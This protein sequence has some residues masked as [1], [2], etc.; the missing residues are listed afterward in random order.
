MSPYVYGG[1]LLVIAVVSAR[2]DAADNPAAIKLGGLRQVRA[3]VSRTDDHYLVQVRMLPVSCFDTSTN[4]RI[5]REKA[6]QYAYQ[7][8][9]RYLSTDKVVRFVVSA[10]HVEKT[11]T[12]GKFYLL[13]LK[14]PRAG[15]TR[16]DAEASSRKPASDNTVHMALDTPLF[17]R[18]RD[19]LHT[20]E[21]LAVTLADDLRTT[22]RRADKE[23]KQTEG[24]PLAVA[25]LEERG[26]DNFKKLRGAVADDKLLLTI[27][28]DEILAD[29]TRRQERWQQ[30]L[31]QAVRTHEDKTREKP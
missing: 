18:K 25:E 11:D 8:L 3:T 2:A 30:L 12:E 17:T 13:I 23:K 31:R 6:E 21:R 20:L 7:A 26:E 5:N 22:E 4:T 28:K 27:E 15:V 1:V 19:H 24:F 16:L 9:A 29:L 10:A 14:V